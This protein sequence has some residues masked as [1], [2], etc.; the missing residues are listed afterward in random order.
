MANAPIKDK[1]YDLISLVYHASQGVETC[2]QFATDAKNEGDADAAAFFD[3]AGE[4]YAQLVT[5]GKDLLKG[6]L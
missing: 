4:Q 2:R 3:D 6:R 1:D 5:K